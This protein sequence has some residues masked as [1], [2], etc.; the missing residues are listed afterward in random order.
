MFLKKCKYTEKEK[1]VIVYIAD[2]ITDDVKFS[3]DYSDE[4]DEE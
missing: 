4:S 1:K 2:Y 3:S